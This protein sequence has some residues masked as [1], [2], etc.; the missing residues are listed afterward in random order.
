MKAEVIVI[1]NKLSIRCLLQIPFVYFINELP[2]YF[3]TAYR[4]LKF[5][6]N[7]LDMDKNAIQIRQKH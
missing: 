4:K 2:E 7:R 3:I 6:E 1:L 5:G